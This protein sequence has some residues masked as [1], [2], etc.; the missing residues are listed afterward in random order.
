MHDF[1]SDGFWEPS[2]IRRSYGFDNDGTVYDGGLS[3][4]DKLT[5]EKAKQVVN[6]V[7][8]LYDHDEDIR[9]SKDEWLAGIDAGKRLPDFGL[10]P[11]HHGDDEYEYEI[12]HYEKYHDE[13]TKDEDLVHEEDHVHFRKH[14]E[15]E[16][17][18][19]KQEKLD[20]QPVVEANI[21][22]KFRRN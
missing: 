16:L 17:A 22:P 4:K 21:P 9:I 8:E 18:D 3:V 10:G 2:E 14:D 5:P 6:D 12:H 13:N 19:Q 7:L 15:R 20:A 1:D 11:G